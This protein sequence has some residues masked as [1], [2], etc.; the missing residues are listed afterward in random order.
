M[1]K[2]I[3]R[4]TS[5]LILSIS[6]AFFSS[7]PGSTN[8][9][10]IAVTSISLDNTVVSLLVGDTETLTATV[11][12]ENATNR[13]V[14]WTSDRQNIAT[15]D[16]NGRISARAEG[17]AIIT[18]RAGNQTATATVTVNDGVLIRGTVWAT[19]N[20][21]MPGTFARN[22]EDAGM[23]YQWNRNVGWSATDPIR[24]SNGSAWNDQPAAGTG[25]A[26]IFDPCPTGWRVPSN[27]ELNNLVQSGS[28]WIIVNGVAGRQFGSGNNTIFLPAAGSRSPVTGAG[29]ELRNVGT[30]GNYWSSTRR[31]TFTAHSISFDN[32]NMSGDG[33][34]SSGFSVRCVAE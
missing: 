2:S 5:I 17:T 22:P 30:H 24:S 11:L 9:P 16:T 8:D 1:K 6:I 15:V 7:C 27:V 14:T 4:I 23:F 33:F 31:D 21:D 10:D 3:S 34:P 19:R 18:A 13:T 28:T 32:L 26:A 29:G 12:P 20:V 25:W